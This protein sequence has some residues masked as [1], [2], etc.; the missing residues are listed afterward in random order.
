MGN[1]SYCRFENTYNDLKDCY[2]AIKNGDDLSSSEQAY[3]ERLIKLCSK[4]ML[5]GEPISEEGDDG[6]EEENDLDV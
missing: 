4:I 2:Q 3:K 1:M 6:Y 5:C